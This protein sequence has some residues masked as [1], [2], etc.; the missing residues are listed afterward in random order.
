M[1]SHVLTPHT[2]SMGKLWN[3]CAGQRLKEDDCL[4][5]HSLTSAGTHLAQGTA[6]STGADHGPH[7]FF[8]VSIL[9]Q[10]DARVDPAGKGELL[11]DGFEV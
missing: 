7:P 11:A 3:D 1:V 2:Y 8:G 4:M 10:A 9:A 6:C 5:K